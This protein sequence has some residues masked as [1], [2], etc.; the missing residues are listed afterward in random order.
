MSTFVNPSRSATASR[1]VMHTLTLAVGP[2]V[3]TASSALGNALASFHCLRFYSRGTAVKPD[4]YDVRRGIHIDS[5]IMARKN[6]SA[7]KYLFACPSSSSPR[8]HSATDR[9]HSASQKDVQVPALL[10]LRYKSS[11]AALKSSAKL[12]QLQLHHS[13]SVAILD[14]HSLS[15]H[16]NTSQIL[17]PSSGIFFSK[18]CRLQSES[19]MSAESPYQG[20]IRRG[21]NCQ[22]HIITAGE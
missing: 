5:N 11:S 20:W 21:E 10:H 22:Q 4:I 12:R 14:N 1:M 18:R 7:N 17:K 16:D 3:E 15:H 6:S 13:C 2:R 19:L 9:L 8:S